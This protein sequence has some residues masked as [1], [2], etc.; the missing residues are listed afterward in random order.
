MF[1]ILT[2]LFI[3]M[4]LF[5]KY[6]FNLFLKQEIFLVG[7]FASLK[8]IK[9]PGIAFSMPISGLILKVLT[10]L[11][12]AFLT[13]YFFKFEKKN[14]N[15]I[16]IL[17]YSLIL[18]GAIGNGIERIFFNQ[19]TD[20]LKIKNFAVMNFGDIFI[21]IGTIILIFFYNKIGTKKEK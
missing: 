10:V 2:L 8:L 16:M 5:S 7:N 3:I 20:F 12:I 17:T 13:Y 21:T 6:L 14:K 1:F 9:N 18:G 19:V 11:I 15:N 4:D